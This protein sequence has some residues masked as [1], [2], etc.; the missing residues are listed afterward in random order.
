MGFLDKAFSSVGTLVGAGVGFLAGG[1]MGAAIGAGIGSA[2]DTSAAAQEAAGIQ[3][4]AAQQA[5]V[6]SLEALKLQLAAD[7][8]ALDKTLAAQQAAAAAGD[9]AAAAALDKQLALQRELYN[10]QVETLAP[11]TKAGELGQNR[12][13]DLMG[14]S[15][16]TAAPG[17]GSATRGFTAADMEV[18]PGYAFRL[19][20]GQ[21]AIDRSTAAKL[22]LQS[23]AALKA[24][25]R[26][27]QEMGS[28][29]YGNAYTRF[30]A[31]RENELSNLRSLQAVGQASAAGQA[32]AAGNLSQ[33][34]TQ[35]YGNYGATGA[36]I[37][38]RTGA[39]ATSA[40]AGSNASRQSAY[41]TN[42]SNQIAAITGGANALAAG[43][44]GSANAF[45][46]LLGQG[47]NAYGM[48]NQNQ[49]LNKY[50]A[51]G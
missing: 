9:A 28:Q 45:S 6:T 16:N 43:Q 51:R 37:A 48:Y 7:K 13:L 25:A 2:S 49:L 34:G 23:G 29:E 35:S 19:S 33:A 11:Y 12:L 22:G 4:G 40:Y 50:L 36:D 1:P 26:Y 10:R 3:A 17:Y 32:T 39:G 14:L 42:A 21:K 30:M 5:G 47:I 31:Q 27:G 44:V 15:G 18:D 20:E 41:G 38:A 8:E 24:A 46:N